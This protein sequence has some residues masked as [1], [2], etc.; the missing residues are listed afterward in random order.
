MNERLNKV[1][2]KILF[3]STG[4]LT[5][6]REPLSDCFPGGSSGKE[7]A[8]RFQRRKRRRFDPWVR[9]IPWR[10][11]WQPTP[12]FLPRESH[13]QRSLMGY[14][15]WGHK[16]SEMTNSL[17]SYHKREFYFSEE[18]H[19]DWQHLLLLAEERWGAL[20]IEFMPLHP[21]LLVKPLPTGRSSSN[22]I[23]V[24]RSWT[25]RCWYNR[26]VGP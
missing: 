6:N 22:N 8:C 4:K 9:K 20:L 17:T 21:F 10:R 15:P 18:P 24:A 16:E 5:N 25:T 23:T 7:P 14:S 19:P 13:E 11:T 1:L 26:D 2:N 12:V 3:K